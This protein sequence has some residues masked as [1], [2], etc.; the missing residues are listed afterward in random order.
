MDSMSAPTWGLNLAATITVRSRKVKKSDGESRSISQ[1]AF[2]ACKAIRCR[3]DIC[4]GHLTTNVRNR[5]S[6]WT[7]T[8]SE[9]RPFTGILP[10]KP[11]GQRIPSQRCVTHYSC[12]NSKCQNAIKW[13]LFGTAEVQ[14]FDARLRAEVRHAT[15][16][17]NCLMN[18]L[19]RRHGNDQQR[20]IP[21][22]QKRRNSLVL[23]NAPTLQCEC[24]VSRYRTI[25]PGRTCCISSWY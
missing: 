8:G 21:G 1:T 18:K 4:R 9:T 7:C 11:N 3:L 22:I 24:S 17:D 25:D 20:S 23:A 12:L 13:Q 5:R 15:A 2:A 19:L 6:D 16:S 10:R 14:F